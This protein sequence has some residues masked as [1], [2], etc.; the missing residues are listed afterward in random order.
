MELWTPIY[1]FH[2]YSVSDLGRVRND[3]RDQVL[4][5][6]PTGGGNMHVGMVK[7]G[8]QRNRSLSLLVAQAY[9]KSPNPEW[10]LATPI[11]LDGDKSNCAADNLMWRPRWFANQYTRQFDMTF[12]KIDPV[13]DMETGLVFRN[14]WTELIMVHGL[15]FWEIIQSIES[16]TY[17]FPTFQ[18]FEWA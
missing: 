6:F 12:S 1:E 17:V 14:I 5:A 18:R 7:E 15:L 13:R 3:R 2:G 16:R 8:V 4:K 10:S 9:L 11:C